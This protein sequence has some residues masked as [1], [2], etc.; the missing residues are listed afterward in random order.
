MY[1]LFTENYNMT[2]FTEEI[3]WIKIRY[4]NLVQNGLHPILK[5]SMKRVAGKYRIYPRA[6]WGEWGVDSR[7][8]L[9]IIWGSRKGDRDS[10]YQF[11]PCT[12]ST[13]PI[14][15]LPPALLRPEATIQ[16][17]NIKL[18]YLFEVCT[19]PP[20]VF[21]QP[22]LP[23]LVSSPINP[24]SCCLPR[25]PPPLLLS[26]PINP[27]TPAISPPLPFYLCTP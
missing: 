14:V 21:F 20:P 24:S 16:A 4:Y 18:K 19:L 26:P 5:M 2:I 13:T 11:S 17:I 6:R 1:E 27:S 9:Q 3:V 22:S 8:G 25:P 23:L 12:I 7:I 15:I 10:E